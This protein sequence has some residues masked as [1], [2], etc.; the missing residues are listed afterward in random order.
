MYAHFHG[1]HLYW[2]VFALHR[3]IVVLAKIG[4]HSTE[5][6]VNINIPP[7]SSIEDRDAE[8]SVCCY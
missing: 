3:Y 8:W 2:H 6:S 5:I 4:P 1:K 7:L